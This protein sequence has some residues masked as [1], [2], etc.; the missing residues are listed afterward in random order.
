MSTTD[1]RLIERVY[2]PQFTARG[3]R[4]NRDHVTGVGALL[5]DDLI[6]IPELGRFVMAEAAVAGL[7]RYYGPV[8]DEAAM[9]ALHAPTAYPPRW[10]A[11]GD[12]CRRTDTG[13]V[14]ECV[15]G[16]G[17]NAADW[18]ALASHE[19]IT[20][21]TAAIGAT[22]SS[23]AALADEVDGKWDTPANAGALSR[24]SAEP[25]GVMLWDGLPLSGGGGGGGG[26]YIGEFASLTALLS[27]GA[28]VGQTARITG[29]GRLYLCINASSSL[30]ASW[31]WMPATSAAIITR[32]Y[33]RLTAASMIGGSGVYLGIFRLEFGAGGAWYPT[34]PM[35]SDASPS[36]LVASMDSQYTTYAA[37]RAFDG[38]NATQAWTGPGASH[39]IQL[40]LG[41]GNGIRPDSVRLVL[42]LN[43]SGG[44]GISEMT[45]AISDTGAFAGEQETLY[46]VSALPAWTT[47]VERT[48]S[49]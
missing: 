43:T 33:V 44:S 2:P 12:K 13:A 16:N 49:W 30:A 47:G 24:I 32:R 40:D 10:V 36:P 14:M 39:W 20:A 31:I 45:V 5:D 37:Y 29:L 19:S 23:I 8:A 4:Y 3:W 15:A 48:Y 11:A 9:L 6:W 21:L 34:A 41:V 27:A 46:S 42:D 38:D 22:D 35:T 26:G 7:P 28:E 1:P 17:T 25:G 18:L